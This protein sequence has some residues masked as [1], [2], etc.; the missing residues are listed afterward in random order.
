MTRALL[1]LALVLGTCGEGSDDAPPPPD[2]EPP[3]SPGLTGDYELLWV[4]HPGQPRLTMPDAAIGAVEGCVW[5]RWSWSFSPEGRLSIQN[6]MLC[7]APAEL[8]AGYGVC[9]ASFDTAVRWREDGFALPVPV[10]AE[11]RFVN[12]RPS[13]DGFG[14]ATV[15]CNVSVGALDATLV[16]AEGGTEDRP[17]EV[18]LRLADGGQ[19]RLRAIESRDAD[20]EAIIRAEQ[21]DDG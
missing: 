15:S 17:D 4:E 8:G 3:S 10:R 18:T 20:H 12:L 9:R 21:G 5:A 1:A 13:G 19:M 7:H 2:P 14:R 16:E 6:E 11:S